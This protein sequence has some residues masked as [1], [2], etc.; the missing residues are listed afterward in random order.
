MIV[1][2]NPIAVDNEINIIHSLFEEGLMLFHVRKPHFEISQM[3]QFL[4]NINSSY[5]DRLVLHTHHDLTKELG[6]NRIHFSESNRKVT[7]LSSTISSFAQYKTE[8]LRLST[9]VHSIEDFNELDNSFEYAFLAPVYQSIS[10]VNYSS[11]VNQF[12]AIKSRNNYSTS[13][14]A[15]GGIESKNIKKTLKNG[16][17]EVAILGTIWNRNNPIE[18]FKSCQKI[19][20]SF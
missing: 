20:Q 18:N 17:D 15:L 2:S 8:G 9:S 5:R 16:F 14:V 4:L 6:I 13:L 7:L 11:K 1:I 19:V 3:K 12:E 10:K